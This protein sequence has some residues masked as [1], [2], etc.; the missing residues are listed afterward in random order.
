MYLIAAVAR[1]TV[2]RHKDEFGVAVF[3]E[4]WWLT[5]SD[6]GLELLL[7][8]MRDGRKHNAAVYVGSHDTDDIGPADSEKGRH[9]PRSDPTPAPLPPDDSLACRARPGVPRRRCRRS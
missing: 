8:L 2:M 9:H 4:C 6:E 5:S 7:E 3:D 1:E